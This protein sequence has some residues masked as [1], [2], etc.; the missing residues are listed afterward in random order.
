MS[1]LFVNVKPHR[2]NA[3]HAINIHGMH[4]SGVKSPNARTT[5]TCIGYRVTKRN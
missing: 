3:K 5:D 4:N 2:R 1:I